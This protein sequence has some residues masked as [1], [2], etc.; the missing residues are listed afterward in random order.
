MITFI[1]IYILSFIGMY[2]WTRSAHSKNGIFEEVN[3][4]WFDVYLTI[5]PIFNSFALFIVLL[6]YNITGKKREN[7]KFKFSPN[8]FFNIKK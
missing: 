2:F 1:I 7:T 5:F 8:K 3:V 4:T 6:G